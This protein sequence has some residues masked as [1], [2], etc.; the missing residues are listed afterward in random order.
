M[1]HKFLT[2]KVSR[3]TVVNDSCFL[4]FTGL[5]YARPELGFGTTDGLQKIIF[6]FF[7]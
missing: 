3:K 1:G 5:A 6:Q 4:I 7:N 2:Y